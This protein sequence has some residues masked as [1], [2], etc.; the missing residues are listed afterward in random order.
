MKSETFHEDFARH[1]E[2]TP[3]SDRR[4]GFA[5]A[6]FL[7]LLGCL[8]VA[9]GGRPR[10]WPLVTAAA[11]ALVALASPA[12]LGPVHRLMQGFARLMHALVSPVALALLFFAGIT[13]LGLLMRFRGHDPLR[14]R[15]EPGLES[16]WVSRPLGGPAPD[17][18]RNQF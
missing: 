8:P 14:R 5:A 9:T 13:P 10:A 15:L 4:F 1:E 7:T 16:Y 18:M 12:L 3:P 17:T 2:V 6:G 11:L